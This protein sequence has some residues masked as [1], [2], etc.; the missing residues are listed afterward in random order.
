[1]TQNEDYI[2]DIL[3][4]S[5]LVTPSQIERAR[6]EKKKDETMVETLIE[7][8]VVTQED[9]TRALAAHSAMDFVDL[10]QM[11]LSDN[12]IQMVPPDVAKRFK[13]VPVAESETGLMI[14][15]SDPLN[16]DVFDSL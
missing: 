8:G 14:A 4:E 5:S 2:L 15:V 16:F 7:H 10:A 12:V 11:A 6:A 1:M 9:V 3:L 13:V